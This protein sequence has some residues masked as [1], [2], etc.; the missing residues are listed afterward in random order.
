MPSSQTENRVY[1]F[2][3]WVD[4]VMWNT[5]PGKGQNIY[6]LVAATLVLLIVRKFAA[7]VINFEDSFTVRATFQVIGW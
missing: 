6:I 7:E 1:H 2:P 5:M 4:N 3:I